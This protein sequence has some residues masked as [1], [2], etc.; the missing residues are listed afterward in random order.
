[1]GV[2]YW[3]QNMGDDGWTCGT[4]VG[5]GRVTPIA[6]WQMGSEFPVGPY[7]RPAWT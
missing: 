2:L 5:K 6:R 3:W 4:C 1:M 7:R